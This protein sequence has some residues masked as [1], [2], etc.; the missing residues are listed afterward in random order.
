MFI[1]SWISIEEKLIK[2]FIL[3]VCV[4]LKGSANQMNPQLTS[5][6]SAASMVR[7]A[8]EKDMGNGADFHKVFNWFYSTTHSQ[9]L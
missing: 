8:S 9:R 3:L 6:P 5:S 1:E 2:Y 7:N 4:M